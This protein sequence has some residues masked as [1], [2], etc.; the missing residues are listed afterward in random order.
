LSISHIKVYPAKYCRLVED[1][2]GIDLLKQL[3]N[4]EQPY[5][6]IKDLAR[7]VLNHCDRVK[8]TDMIL[9]G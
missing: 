8:Q 7:M 2:N 6:R 9:D 3:L 4:N 5:E 1:E